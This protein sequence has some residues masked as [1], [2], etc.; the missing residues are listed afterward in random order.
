MRIWSLSLGLL[1]HMGTWNNFQKVDC[2]LAS[3]RT[4]RSYENEYYFY[5]PADRGCF[6][7]LL[8]QP[9]G[10]FMI[11]RVRSKVDG[12]KDSKWTVQREMTVRSEV[13]NLDGLKE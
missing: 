12:P 1:G 4:K 6:D 8:E 9:L 13:L 11:K 5:I 10:T 2:A 7:Q 3:P